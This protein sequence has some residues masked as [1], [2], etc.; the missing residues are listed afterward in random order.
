MKGKTLS[1]I[2]APYVFVDAESLFD[3]SG[4]FKITP[5]MRY[6]KKLESLMRVVNVGM[7]IDKKGKISERRLEKSQFIYTLAHKCKYKEMVD[8]MRDH[9]SFILISAKR[10]KIFSWSRCAVDIE[11]SVEDI[12]AELGY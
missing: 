4:I 9:S 2:P 3:F 10:A 1:N 11:N 5:K 7:F 12:L 8:I 6:R